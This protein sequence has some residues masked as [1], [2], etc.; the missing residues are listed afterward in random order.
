[1]E[2][3]GQKKENQD[4]G[5]EKYANNKTLSG[6]GELASSNKDRQP[7]TTVE[8]QGLG[9]TSQDLAHT[10]TANSPNGEGRYP[11][12]KPADTG[13]W[14]AVSDMPPKEPRPIFGEPSPL[15]GGPKAPLWVRYDMTVASERPWPQRSLEDL[16]REHPE[17]QL[18]DGIEPATMDLAANAIIHVT[19]EAACQ[20]LNKWCPGLS[21]LEVFESTLVEGKGELELKRYTV[22]PEA[23]GKGETVV[24]LNNIYQKCH[25]VYPKGLGEIKFPKLLKLIDVC[26]AFLGGI[27]DSEHKAL[28]QRTK[29]KFQWIPV[30]LGAKKLPLLQQASADL[31][32]LE[33]LYRHS[34][35]NGEVDS[36]Y[37]RQKRQEHELRILDAMI[38]QFD[39]HRMNFEAEMLE[40]LNEL[41]TAMHWLPPKWSSLK[42]N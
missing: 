38:E 2:F 34:I 13:S 35:T 3:T 9:K 37:L 15:R 17:K 27:N 26:V 33:G 5:W 20:W 39:F 28:L 23:I 7:L 21:L 1:M 42:E 41:L 8:S 12:A 10:P 22:P 4:G 32:D 14:G 11:P 36:E 31:R 19:N 16:Y 24:S 40:W 30:G 29:S 6:F 25:T 18:Q